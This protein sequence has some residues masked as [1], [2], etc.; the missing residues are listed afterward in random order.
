M[1]FTINFGSTLTA[2][3]RTFT[4]TITIFSVTPPSLKPT[5]TKISLPVG[6]FPEDCVS[7][8]PNITISMAKFSKPRRPELPTEILA[9]ILCLCSPADLLQVQVVSRR[10]YSV[11]EDNKECWRSA[12]ENFSTP[13]PPPPSFLLTNAEA[14]LATQLFAGGHC[15][16]CK[17]FTGGHP[18]GIFPGIRFCS[19][20]C[21]TMSLRKPA[22]TDTTMPFF[23]SHSET[24]KLLPVEYLPILRFWKLRQHKQNR[25]FLERSQVEVLAS[26]CNAARQSSASALE[27]LLMDGALQAAELN[28]R[29]GEINKVASWFTRYHQDVSSAES[30]HIIENKA[31]LVNIASEY[32]LPPK[33]LELSPVF[34]RHLNSYIRD[35]K[36]LDKKVW[37]RI[38]DVVLAE[39]KARLYPGNADGSAP[40]GGVVC[41]ICHQYKKRRRGKTFHDRQAY[42][43]HMNH[44]HGHAIHPAPDVNMLVTERRRDTYFSD[45]A[46]RPRSRMLM[47]P[48]A[49]TLPLPLVPGPSRA[50]FDFAHP[51]NNLAGTVEAASVWGMKYLNM[52]FSCKLADSV[53]VF[54]I[55][56][57]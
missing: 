41:T 49:A 19:S 53:W 13:I 56:V 51:F 27:Q 39:V 18:R 54:L 26:K 2:C 34:A 8:N 57:S 28:S 43:N 52:V 6:P 16:W 24:L 25:I 45:E 14:I 50:S 35:E 21:K 37:L 1:R 23:I 44:S 30:H 17:S 36:V 10:F 48:L 29:L 46:P 11:L 55:S 12:R 31:F 40:P 4:I 42:F 7:Y 5:C 47:L 15:V 9:L 3:S 22:P 38:R 32:K 33:H 20:H